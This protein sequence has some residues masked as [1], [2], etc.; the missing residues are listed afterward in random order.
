MTRILT[1]LLCL[2]VS[3]TCLFGQRVLR[4]RVPDSLSKYIISKVNDAI[5]QYRVDYNPSL[6]ASD[7]ILRQVDGQTIFRDPAWILFED[8]EVFERPELLMQVSRWPEHNPIPHY[9]IVTKW[10]NRFATDYTY[11]PYKGKLRDTLSS[12]KYDSYN[13]FFPHDERFL[14][15]YD[16]GRDI[17]RYL[18]GNFFQDRINGSWYIFGSSM[19]PEVRLAQ[20]GVRPVERFLIKQDTT[21]YI[22]PVCAAITHG[23]PGRFVVKTLEQFPFDY[24]EIIYY[25]N[26]AAETGDSNARHFYE[27][28]QVRDYTKG[29]P[30]ARQ[31]MQPTVRLLGMREIAVLEQYYG[32]P[33]YNL[34]NID[35][36]GLPGN[37]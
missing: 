19:I 6:T 17:F 29:Y 25:S 23:T 32:E 13:S 1:I 5:L 36:A 4:E 30:A 26:K 27:I 28:R 22:M 33:V 11:R 14:V 16:E 3:N 2:M 10:D 7:K 15:Y 37:K 31:V 21:V 18:S 24:L 20:Y 12:K 8:P 34:G 9:Y 35:P